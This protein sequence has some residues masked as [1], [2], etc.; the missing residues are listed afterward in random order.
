[1]GAQ[2]YTQ[3]EILYRDRADTLSKKWKLESTLRKER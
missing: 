2:R 3:E 1:M